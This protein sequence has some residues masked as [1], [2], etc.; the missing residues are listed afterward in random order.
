MKRI[1]ACMVII[2]SI[3]GVIQSLHAQ[4]NSFSPTLLQE[5]F[6]R[7]REILEN[8]H[9]CLYEYASKAELDSLF[10]AHYQLIDR[11]MT[12]DNF[13]LYYLHPLPQELDVCILQHGCR[14]GFILQNP[15]NCSHL[16]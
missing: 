15:I 6:V 2:H 1:I 7:F 4:T 13:F 9:C 3:A 11:E 14:E 12:R 16:N 8:E 10:D 5:D